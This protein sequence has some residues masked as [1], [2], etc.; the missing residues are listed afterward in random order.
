MSV[1]VGAVHFR[2]LLLWE[3]FTSVE[4]PP[5]FTVIKLVSLFVEYPPW[6]KQA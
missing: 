6:G 5:V 3:L 2:K 1:L 4:Y